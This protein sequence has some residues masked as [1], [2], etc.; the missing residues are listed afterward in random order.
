[1]G[2]PASSKRARVQEAS[3]SLDPPA[4]SQTYPPSPAEL[5]GEALQSSPNGEQHAE[6]QSQYSAFVN[7]LYISALAA[8]CEA[9]GIRLNLARLHL[10]SRA[11]QVSRRI[12]FM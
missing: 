8:P 11:C 5:E 7:V 12:P 3:H 9:R 4:T 2:S 10:D 1:M 6:P